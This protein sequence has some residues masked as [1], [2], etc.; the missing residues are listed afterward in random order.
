MYKICKSFGLFLNKAGVMV[1][2]IRSTLIALVSM[3]RNEKRRVFKG[4]K[5]EEISVYG[6][7]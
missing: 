7:C 2:R 4:T 1:S 6:S 5:V 3:Y